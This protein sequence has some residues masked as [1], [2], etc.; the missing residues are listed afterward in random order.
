M[1]I[2]QGGCVAD[3]ATPSILMT[4]SEEEDKVT[5]DVVS[6]VGVINVVTV[7]L[8]TIPIT[9]LFLYYIINIIRYGKYKC[10]CL[11]YI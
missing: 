3:G 1:D 9:L 11:K 10:N 7:I 6:L 5:C 2:P 4:Y 8:I